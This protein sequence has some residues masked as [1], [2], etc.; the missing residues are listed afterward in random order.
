LNEYCRTNKVS[1]ISCSVDGVFSKVFNDFGM[2]FEVL[3]KN[4]E[5]C[6]EL[7]INCITNEENGVVTLLKG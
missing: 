4:G 5:E 7:F 6:P 1:F 3:D 2:D